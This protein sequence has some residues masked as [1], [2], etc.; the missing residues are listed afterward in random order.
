MDAKVPVATR[1]ENEV[2]GFHEAAPLLDVQNEALPLGAR[3]CRVQHVAC[4]RAQRQLGD[5]RG[6]PAQTESEATFGAQA[7]ESP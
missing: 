6:Q 1:K 4:R 2:A 5:G 3:L 7:G